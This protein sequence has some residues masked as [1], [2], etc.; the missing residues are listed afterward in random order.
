[1]A[2]DAAYKL[3]KHLLAYQ[4][5]IK[6]GSAPCAA[7]A[8]AATNAM[9]M[10]AKYCFDGTRSSYLP[11]KGATRTD[12]TLALQYAKTLDAYNNN[13]PCPDGPVLFSKKSPAGGELL[14]ASTDSKLNAYPNPYT[15]KATIEFTLEEAGEY[16]LVLYDV[17]GSVVKNI[18]SGKADAGKVYS[19]EIGH[20]NMPE[21]IYLA[22]LSTGKFSKVVRI[23][24]RR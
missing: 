6:S 8:T 12:Y 4:L 3:A 11:N 14:A 20:N 1:M 18:G 13:L 16:T 15:D 9:A 21:G 5:N 23:S 7:A 19:F 22:R 10:L 24:L 2:S 17:K